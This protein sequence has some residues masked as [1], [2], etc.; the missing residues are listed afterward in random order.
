MFFADARFGR[1]RVLCGSPLDND[2]I[3]QLERLSRV[4]M[5]GA[6]EQLMR[7]TIDW[8]HSPNDRTNAAFPTIL[9]SHRS[10]PRIA[11]VIGAAVA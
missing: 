10:Q 8:W 7:S 11:A 1:Q 5:V 4:L 9:L 3:N 6:S 2:I